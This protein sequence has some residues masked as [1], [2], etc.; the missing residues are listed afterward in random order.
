MKTSS[1][2]I[3]NGHVT[4]NEPDLIYEYYIDLLSLVMI[5]II[6][7][8]IVITILDCCSILQCFQLLVL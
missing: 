8:N 7:S 2:F 5:I 3:M 1:N 6:V 4:V